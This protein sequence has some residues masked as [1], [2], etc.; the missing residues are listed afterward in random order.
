MKISKKFFLVGF[1]VFGILFSCNN[2]DMEKDSDF[3]EFKAEKAAWECQN[4][5]K[6][7]LTLSHTKGTECYTSQAVVSKNIPTYLETGILTPENFP[8][9]PFAET[10][11]DIYETLEGIWDNNSPVIIT[12]DA[13]LHIPKTVEI[14]NY[15]DVG[16]EYK[17]EIEFRSGS[18]ANTNDP[19]SYWQVYEDGFYGTTAFTGN[20]NMIGKPYPYEPTT[21]I[22][23]IQPITPDEVEQLRTPPWTLPGTI[24]K[25]KFSITFPTENLLLPE[26]Y[27]K[28]TGGIKIAKV[29]IVHADSSGIRVGL[30]KYDMFDDNYRSIDI[31]YAKAEKEVA[32]SYNGFFT[33]KQGWNFVE[34]RGIEKGISIS[35]NI[36]DYLKEG[37]HWKIERWD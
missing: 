36:E 30:H 18:E 19:A 5:D 32:D 29:A 4:I 22:V 15:K 11:G 34:S 2:M 17:L 28:Y 23:D 33:L 31:Y 12:Y 14:K 25:G 6:S 10:I 24:T 35:Q 21:Q 13:Q 26:I 37:Y 8:F 7:Y 20:A 1:F 27:G 9:K 16:E 3:I